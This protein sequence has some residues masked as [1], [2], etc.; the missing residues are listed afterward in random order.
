MSV[1]YS[2]ESVK[3]ETPEETNESSIEADEHESPVQAVRFFDG[4]DLYDLGFVKNPEDAG[5]KLRRKL[6]NVDG[7][8]EKMIAPSKSEEDQRAPATPRKVSQFKGL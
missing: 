6:W 1:F 3:F 5:R 7:L 4:V 8:T 2:R